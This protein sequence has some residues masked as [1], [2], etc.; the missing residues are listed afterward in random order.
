MYGYTI[1]DIL[2]SIGEKNLIQIQDGKS[3][4]ELGLTRKYEHL[5]CVVCSHA[6][7]P[8]NIQ[9]IQT[10]RTYCQGCTKIRSIR[11]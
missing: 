7:L 8:T 3:L 2:K 1:K 9:N 4:N 5:H 10:D 6:W 11:L